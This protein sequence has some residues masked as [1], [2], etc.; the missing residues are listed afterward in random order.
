LVFSNW[1]GFNNS[2]KTDLFNLRLKQYKLLYKINRLEYYLEKLFISP[3]LVQKVR[4]LTFEAVRE[5]VDVFNARVQ[6]Q[7]KNEREQVYT[8]TTNKTQRNR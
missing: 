2:S 7:C 1:I 3:L 5:H 6:V 8:N 4:K